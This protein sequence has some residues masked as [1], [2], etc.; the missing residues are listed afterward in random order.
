MTKNKI[1]VSAFALFALSSIAFIGCG[2]GGGGGSSTNPTSSLEVLPADYDFGI[3]T[4]G[5]SAQPLEV[6]IRNNGA[7][8][9][10]VTS[11]IL[12][13]TNNFTLDLDG[14]TNPCGSTTPTIGTNSSC[15]VTV[16]FLP[17]AVDTFSA[18]LTIRSN[19]PTAPRYDMS[20]LGSKQAINALNVKINQIDACPRPSPPPATVYVSVTDQ[21]GF[22]VTTLDA[23]NFLI[24][25]VGDVKGTTTA[26]PV[27]D[28]VALSVAL[29]LDYS[30]SI[31]IDP[32]NV[33]A[34]QDAA[35]SFV[36]DLGANDEA[37]I[38]KYGT[39][40][41]VTQSFT[42]NKTLLRAAIQSTPNVG[43]HTAL[44]DA[45]VQAATDFSTSTKARRAIIIIT[46]GIDDDGTG[47][48][49]SI[50]TINEAINDANGNGVPVFTVGLG[51][52]NVTILQQLA[53]D[54]GGTYSDSPTTANLATIY[55]QLSDL[56][57]TNQYILTYDSA[58]A[59]GAFGDLNVEA[60][61]APGISDNDTKTILACP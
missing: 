11:I 6:V 38:I 10:G 51:S 16:D 32:V 56:L 53:D 30:G 60:T 54:T 41:E 7:A 17:S 59:T 28:T 1:I 13:D 18:D 14:G 52:A 8:G 26:I 58:L 36:N 22:P 20:L 4:D 3:V 25:E 44:Y 43:V 2:G 55:Q 27:D 46:D 12:S 39:T 5:N 47:N 48:P 40:I 57:F 61:Y 9:L 15:T 37:E 35:N 24:R 29:V 34:M 42:S 50:N 45:V 49:Q 33:S 31:T 19:D 23:G 21:G